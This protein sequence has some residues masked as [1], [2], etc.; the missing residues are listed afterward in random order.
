MSTCSFREMN[1]NDYDRV[2]ILWRRIPGLGLSGAD[3]REGIRDLLER[4]PGLCFVCQEGER[5]V[6]TILCG[7][8][9]RRGYIYHL[10]VDETCRRRGLGRQLTQLSLDALHRLGISRC[11]LFVYRD[12]EEAEL[13][14][15]RMG[16]QKRTTL[17]IFSREL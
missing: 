1:I 16:W 13:F 5:L 6:G 8:D 9:A 17:D 15:G 14:Y 7:H 2:L 3:S 4:N 12:N 10:A 11:H